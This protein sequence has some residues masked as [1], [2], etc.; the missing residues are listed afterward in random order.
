MADTKYDIFISW[1]NDDTKFKQEE[2]DLDGNVVKMNFTVGSFVAFKLSKYIQTV[3]SNLK[4]YYSKDWKS[5]SWLDN[6]NDGLQNCRLFIFI[7]T[8]H[9]LDSKWVD[10][11][12]GASIALH[13]NV[14]KDKKNFILF[15]LGKV[16]RDNSLPAKVGLQFCDLNS[17]GIEHFLEVLKECFP[18][19][20]FKNKP[21]L[22]VWEKMYKNDVEK[23][24]K[25]INSEYV[26]NEQLRSKF[27]VLA[28]EKNAKIKQLTAEL[29]KYKTADIAKLKEEIQALQESNIRLGSLKFD[30]DD[31]I[32][33]PDSR[34]SLT[35]EKADLL[36]KLK[37]AEQEL[38]NLVKEARK[39]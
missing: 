12:F 28:E 38:A 36:L 39:Y 3:A 19:C 26:S 24:I 32:M 30:F 9:A 14:L 34:I 5:G 31:N 22:S 7:I 23:A 6:L 33:N 29:I 27:N 13:S 11:E 2:E 35:Y 17:S 4:V 15:N 1:A 37:T 25:R 16:N 18:A 21:K 20:D 10:Y 8:Q